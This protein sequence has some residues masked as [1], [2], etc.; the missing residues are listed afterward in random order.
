MDSYYLTIRTS[1]LDDLLATIWRCEEDMITK[2]IKG[3]AYRP[4]R[5][6]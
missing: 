4:T 5:C 1:T 3:V 6:D 2:D